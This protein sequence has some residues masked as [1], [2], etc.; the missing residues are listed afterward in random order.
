MPY[1]SWVSNAAPV[2]YEPKEVE[3]GEVI[4]SFSTTATGGVPNSSYA[5]ATY[6]LAASGAWI[7]P[8]VSSNNS[9]ISRPSVYTEL[10][11]L[12]VPYFSATDT[13]LVYDADANHIT[14]FGEFTLEG[15]NV[16]NDASFTYTGF[17]AKSQTWTASKLNISRNYPRTRWNTG[18]EARFYLSTNSGSTWTLILTDDYDSDPIAVTIFSHTL[19]TV[20]DRKS[21][22]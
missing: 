13:N 1:S 3:S 18:T 15:L 9:E 2:S 22:V 6:V 19:A 16:L 5:P 11:G 21:V 12:P 8:T 17:A 4:T 10:T 7:A 20:K 14:T